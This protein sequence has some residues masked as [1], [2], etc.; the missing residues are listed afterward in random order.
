MKTTMVK[1]LYYVVL[2]NPLKVLVHLT[3]DVVFKNTLFSQIQFRYRNLSLTKM[4]NNIKKNNHLT[5]QRR[6]K[7]EMRL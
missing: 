4:N 5:N 1:I 3:S 2:L 7:I 6:L